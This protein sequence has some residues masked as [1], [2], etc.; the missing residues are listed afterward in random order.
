M[1]LCVIHFILL[2]RLLSQYRKERS[3]DLQLPVTPAPLYVPSAM[4]EKMEPKFKERVI[5]HIPQE[6]KSTVSDTFT[7]KRKVQ[8]NARTRL[9]VD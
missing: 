7:K 6:V 3:I 4:P 2:I 8:R 9:D 5:D 1:F